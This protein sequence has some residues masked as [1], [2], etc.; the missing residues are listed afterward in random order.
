MKPFWCVNH[1]PTLSMY[2]HD[3]DGNTVE[4][5]WDAMEVEEAD[6]FLIS[7]TFK[8]NPIGADFDPEIIL[9]RVERGEDL[10][11]FKERKNVGSRGFVDAP[12]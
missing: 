11:E 12:Q 5:Q 3:P 1:G 2:Y 9:A 8:K 7:E 6:Y 4:T 10:S